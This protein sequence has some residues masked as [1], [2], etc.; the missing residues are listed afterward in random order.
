MPYKK[1]NMAEDL[2]SGTKPNKNTPQGEA[3]PH[4]DKSTDQQSHAEYKIDY[5]EHFE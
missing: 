4:L 3:S 2:F 5:R 1:P